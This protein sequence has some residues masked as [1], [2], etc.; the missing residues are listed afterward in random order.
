MLAR[1]LVQLFSDT[2][3]CHVQVETPDGIL[4]VNS[5]R[6]ASFTADPD[7]PHVWVLSADPPKLDKFR[8]MR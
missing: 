8:V 3:D 7:A 2:P 5:A 4:T 1:D 6:L